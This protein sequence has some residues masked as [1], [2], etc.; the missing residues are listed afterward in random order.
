MPAVI[1]SFFWG[2]GSFTITST[3][4]S[5]IASSLTRDETNKE[6]KAPS[7]RR[8][9][10]VHVT[11]DLYFFF[12]PNL[13]NNNRAQETLASFLRSFIARPVS[14]YP[15]VRQDSERTPNPGAGRARGT[16][17]N[18]SSSSSPS[19][20][21]QS[22]GEGLDLIAL[23]RGAPQGCPG[24]WFVIPQTLMFY[25]VVLDNSAL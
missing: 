23:F 4:I 15:P 6:H 13:G 24:V 21:K 18:T 11:R 5:W 12:R 8:P 14:P 7:V 19:R 1:P 16:R 17:S 25:E 20:S 3:Q 22:E 9:A 2:G 10:G